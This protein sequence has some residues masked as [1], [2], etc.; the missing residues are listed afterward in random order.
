MTGK[1]TYQRLLMILAASVLMAININTFVH[2]GGLIPGGFTGISLLV[3]EICQRYG[4]FHIPFTVINYS[5]NAVPAI[6]CFMYIGR[7][8][9]LYSVLMVAVSS[10]LTDFM[11][12]MFIDF[13][14]V[15]DILLS[16]VFGGLLNAVSISLCLHAGATSGGTD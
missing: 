8:F 5:L 6:I 15:K 14:K 4:G 12:A 7:K 13:L 9:T 11:P 16:T 10:L 1:P 3:Q 2:A